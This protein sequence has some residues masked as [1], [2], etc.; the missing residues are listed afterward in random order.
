MLFA[1]REGWSSPSV[2]SG[3]DPQI[4]E[5]GLDDRFERELYALK[6]FGRIA[7]PPGHRPEA[8][9]RIHRLGRAGNA[10][11]CRVFAVGPANRG[12][13]DDAGWNRIQRIGLL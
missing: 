2:R 3:T 1:D 13:L 6:T 4:A 12:C 9:R 7:A 5:A 11:D 8:A 10:R